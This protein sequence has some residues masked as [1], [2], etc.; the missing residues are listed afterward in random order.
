MY[1]YLYFSNPVFGTGKRLCV[2]TCPSYTDGT[3]ST[4][5]CFEGSC[6]YDVTFNSDGTTSATIA[7]M[8]NTNLVLGYGTTLTLDRVCLPNTNVLS[9]GLSSVATSLTSVLQEG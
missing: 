3:L 4:L 8:N 9:N 5:D 7:S 2:K 6:T 1:P